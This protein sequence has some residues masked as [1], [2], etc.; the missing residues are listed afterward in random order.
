M[1]GIVIHKSARMEGDSPGAGEGN[2]T[3]P[4]GRFWDDA[5][6]YAT[7]LGGRSRKTLAPPAWGA[8]CAGSRF[9]CLGELTADSSGLDAGCVPLEA[10]EEVLAEVWVVSRDD[11]RRP[12]QTEK[13]IVAK[14]WENVGYPTPESQF[15]E[16]SSRASSEANQ[17]EVLSSV[18]SS[19]ELAVVGRSE[20]VASPSIAE[21]LGASVGRSQVSRCVDLR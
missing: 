16:Q 6:P 20:V 5:S 7:A 9:S 11:I 18:C 13:E 3:R 12:V 8:G 21:G 15:W 2:V 19:T 1:H 4:T 10:A 14:F 17:G